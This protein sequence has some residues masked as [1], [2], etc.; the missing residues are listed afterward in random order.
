MRC[1]CGRQIDAITI[2]G[3][4]ALYR[5]EV[6]PDSAIHFRASVKVGIILAS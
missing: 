2:C 6:K 3:Q 4:V 1:G 5:P